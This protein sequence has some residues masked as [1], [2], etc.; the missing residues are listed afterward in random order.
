MDIPDRTGFQTALDDILD[1]AQVVSGYLS[2]NHRMPVCCDGMRQEMR[3][4]DIVLDQPPKGKGATLLIRC[5]L[6]R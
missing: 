6:P 3:P 4:G 2:R 1:V 5:R